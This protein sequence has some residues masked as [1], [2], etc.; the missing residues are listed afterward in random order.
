MTWREVGQELINYGQ[1]M[2]L[3]GGTGKSKPTV[4]IIEQLGGPH[5]RLKSRDKE[6]SL[7][8]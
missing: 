7:V 4:H 6:E 8:G 2:G 1:R 3:T 5:L